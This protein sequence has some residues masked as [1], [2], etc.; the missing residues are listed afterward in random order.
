MPYAEI[1]DVDARLGKLKDALQAD[2]QPSRGD[3][4]RLLEQVSDELDAYI[5]AAGHDVPVTAD[6][7]GAKALTGLVADTVAA[8]ILVGL[9]PN[10]EGPAAASALR[11]FLEKRTAAAWKLIMDGKHPAVLV[12]EA[13]GGGTSADDFWTAEPNY[14]M[15]GWVDP[16][17][18]PGL[19]PAFARDDV[20]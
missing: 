12:I 18:N 10:N 17:T 14:G 19:A 3:A 11:D 15:T 7:P 13:E 1:T 9:F 6:S 4:E 8:Q 5:G 16:N 20:F 2:S